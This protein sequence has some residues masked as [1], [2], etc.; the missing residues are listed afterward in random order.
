MRKIGLWTCCLLI[1]LA[2]LFL[3]F[4]A[5]G[6]HSGTWY[7]VDWVLDDDGMLT[8][9]GEGSVRPFINEE[10]G[11]RAWKEDIRAVVI[12][13]GVWGIEKGTYTVVSQILCKFQIRVERGIY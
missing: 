4:P 3:C 8:V 7:G 11:W 1:L 10:D 9:S 6:E 5:L 2:L 13:E 12:E